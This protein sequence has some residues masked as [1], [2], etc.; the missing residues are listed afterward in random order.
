[1]INCLLIV[2]YPC[3]YFDKNDSG[4]DLTYNCHVKLS[5]V[6]SLGEIM[7]VSLDEVESRYEVFAVSR[8]IRSDCFDGEEYY[9][10]ALKLHD[11]EQ[12]GYDN[13]FSAIVL[14]K[15][16]LRTEFEER[17]FKV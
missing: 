2:E 17:R 4:D 1:M 9:Q 5:S 15:N 12:N 16:F 14:F 13:P 11:T 6:P 7:F 8:C 10:V 3:D